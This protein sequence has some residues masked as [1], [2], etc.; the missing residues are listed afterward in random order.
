MKYAALF[1][2]LVAGTA[3]AA[4]D[5]ESK[6]LLKELE[7]SYKMIAAER[8][9]GP[10][11]AGFLDMIEMVSIKGNKFAIVFKSEGGKNEEKSATITVDAGKK[12]AQIDLKPDD[13]EKKDHTVQGIVVLES[14]TL[15]ICWSDASDAKRPADFK[16]S[17]EDKNMLLTLKKMK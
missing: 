12:P 7:G 8:S 10:P 13:G 4:D 14:G 1:L 6:K 5:A 15:K 2:F 3:S 17:K 9:G 16:T 11:P